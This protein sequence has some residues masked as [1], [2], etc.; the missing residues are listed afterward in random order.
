MLIGLPIMVMRKLK[1]L[2][3]FHNHPSCLCTQAL[4]VLDVFVL[5]RLAPF[6]I[7]KEKNKEQRANGK[8]RTCKNG[9]QAMKYYY[10]KK[11]LRYSCRIDHQ[12]IQ[13]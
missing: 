5:I 9:I 8:I 10:G 13:G 2:F 6:A 12:D 3:Q 7:Q 4:L 1:G 11:Q